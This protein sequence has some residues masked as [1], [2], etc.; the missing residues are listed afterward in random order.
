MS[1]FFHVLFPVVTL[2]VA[3]WVLFEPYGYGGA[4]AFTFV[5][6]ALLEV[7]WIAANTLA[8]WRKP[9]LALAEAFAG[10]A[11]AMLVVAGDI[12]VGWWTSMLMGMVVVCAAGLTAGYICAL[13]GLVTRKCFQRAR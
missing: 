12:F 11:L 8:N 2:L 7:L 10:G 1:H 6:W 13:A 4:Y 5:V 9:F 3:K